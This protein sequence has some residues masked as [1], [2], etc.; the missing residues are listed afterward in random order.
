MKRKFV[1]TVVLSLTAAL[2]ISLAA[3]AAWVP[4]I[5]DGSYDPGIGGTVVVPGGID[6]IQ[7]GTGTAIGDRIMRIGIYYGSGGKY[8]ASLRNVVGSGFQFG[9]Y[10]SAS[11]SEVFVPLAVTDRTRITVVRTYNVYLDGA[12]GYTDTDMGFGAVG[13]YHVQLPGGFA[14]YQ[15][16]AMAAQQYSG[17][18]VSYT[19]GMFYVRMGAYTNAQEAY[20]AAAN[21]GAS[22]GETSGW[23]MSV[24]ETGTANILFQYDDMGAGTGL[25]VEP[26]SVTGQKAVTKCGYP[27]YGGFRFERFASY[28]GLMTVVNLIRMDDYVKG[29]VPYESSASWPIEAL[30]AQA[31][32]ARTYALTHIKSAHQRGFH[33]DLCDTTD[34]QAYK[35]VYSN[36]LAYKI[37][38]AVDGTAGV[39][40]MYEGQYCDTV[41][42]SSN[43]GASESAVNVWGKDLPYLIGT[44][45]P[46]EALIADT[47]PNYN[48]T[49]TYTGQE[50]QQALIANGWNAGEVVEVKTEFTEMGNVYALTF[51]DTNGK[52]FSVYK[53][54]CRTFLKLRSMRY[55]VSGN[56]GGSVTPGG[57]SSSGLVTDTG[58]AIDLTQGVT[59]IDGNG[60]FTTVTGGYLITGAGTVQPVETTPSNTGSSGQ[61]GQ[62]RGN[63]FYFT[64]TGWGHN[65]G[66]SQYGAC[67]MAQQGYTFRQILEFYYTGVTVS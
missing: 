20:A 61:V 66:L 36:S 17:G 18:F 33:F 19:G 27:Y 12:G 11:G 31:V 5:P 28:D 29:V 13:W 52:S 6:P 64:G 55:T 16:A 14:T 38:E 46:F 63:V 39:T 9:Y 25:G 43:G 1:Q 53:T 3:S 51:V 8:A 2:G 58:A 40:V 47:I 42:S 30:K 57:S 50:L 35:G 59:V 24:V 65:V 45:D 41:Y 15:E 37:D 21:M 54:S 48:W 62:A 44:E 60:N 32:C 26:V 49:I 4:S 67:A 23:G 56:Q 22:V 7:P 10:D 34:C